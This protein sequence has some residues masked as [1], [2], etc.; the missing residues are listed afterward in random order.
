[1]REYEVSILAL[2]GGRQVQKLSASYAAQDK[3]RMMKVLEAFRG[4][5]G[6]Q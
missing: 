6:P 3:H 5:V 2:Q 1:M 4:T